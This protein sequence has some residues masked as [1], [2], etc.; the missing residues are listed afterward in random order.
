MQLQLIS[1]HGA[2]PGW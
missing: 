1:A 2:V